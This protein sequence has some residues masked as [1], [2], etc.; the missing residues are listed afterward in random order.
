M[1]DSLRSKLHDGSAVVGII[2]LGYVG[3]PLAIG[4]SRR[5][6]VIGFDISP[7][8]VEALRRGD[9]RVQGVAREDLIQALD[10]RFVPTTAF[11]RLAECDI[12]VICVGTPLKEGRDPDLSQVECAAREISR[13][14]RPGQ[15]VVFEST[16]YPRT[17]E[18]VIMPILERSGLRLGIDFGVAYS[19][20]RIDPGNES[21]RLENIPKL[22]GGLDEAS[23]TFVREFYSQVVKVVIPVSHVRVAEAAKI[24]ENLFRAVNIALANEI[25]L[26]MELLD[27]DAW[28]AIRAASTKPFGFAAFYP[29]PGVGGHC[30]PLDPYYLSY[31]ARKAGY[32]PR[33]IELS[34]DINEYMKFHVVE[35]LHRG[36]REAGKPISGSTVAILG[37]SFKKNV[38]DTRE[39]PAIRIIEECMREGMQVRVFDPHAVSITT[40]QGTLKSEL[41]AESALAE[42]DAGILLVDHEQFRHLD[43]DNL[44]RLMADMP[45]WIDTRGVLSQAPKGSIALGIGRPSGRIPAKPR[46]D[47]ALPEPE[48]PRAVKS[49]T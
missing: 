35:L 8:L 22:V 46:E 45:V 25:A 40:R 28:E 38:A 13:R 37:L 36:L 32:M 42:A 24:I 39:S 12:I 9:A 19:P 7:E 15:F 14:L 21:Y 43:Y 44:S 2:G 30:I 41:D 18:E 10:S 49:R 23:T 17:T 1:Y 4:F 47:V 5:F 48:E 34:G 20:E 3:L 16:S 6:R 27:I 29:G 11:D 31:R 26:I 33:F